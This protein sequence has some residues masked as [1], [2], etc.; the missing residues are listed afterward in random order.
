MASQFDVY[1]S[2]PGLGVRLQPEPL[3]TT[4]FGLRV[5]S[6]NDYQR[7]TVQNGLREGDMLLSLDGMTFPDPRDF[8]SCL[9]AAPFTLRVIRKGATDDPGIMANE[10]LLSQSSS[11]SGSCLPNSQP[12][13]E[14]KAMRAL[15]QMRLPPN[16]HVGTASGLG[17]NCLID[18]LFQALDPSL[19]DQNGLR[20]EKAPQC[21]QALMAQGLCND[22]QFLDTSHIIHILRLLDQNVERMT[23]FV[24]SFVELESQIAPE[25]IG[26]G[27]RIIFIANVHRHMHFD[28]VFTNDNRIHTLAEIV[29]GMA[30]A[31]N[32]SRAEMLDAGINELLFTPS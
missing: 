11:S 32:L 3:S 9:K 8:I 29:A 25:R 7:A 6:I 12:A 13:L 28:P 19:I 2:E 17:N 14:T 21:R 24:L 15:I 4:V 18:S 1:I 22:S 20:E 16:W 27:E 5:V 31:D 26:T 10:M 23:I 30:N